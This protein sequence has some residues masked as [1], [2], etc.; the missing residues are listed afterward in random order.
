VVA[1]LEKSLRKIAS[2]PSDFRFGVSPDRFG[3][4]VWAGRAAAILNSDE[5]GAARLMPLGIFK[6]VYVSNSGKY[7]VLE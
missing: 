1:Q 5:T 2:F 6:A 7:L 3:L 4:N